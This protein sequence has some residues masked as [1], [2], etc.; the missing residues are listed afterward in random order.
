MQIWVDAD[1]C[2]KI[3]KE[4]LFRT[5]ERVK[6]NVT[7]V[8]NN[9]S[10]TPSS[11]YIQTIQVG[12]GY[13]VADKEIV[14]KLQSGDLVITAD[15][16][17]AAEVIKKGGFALSP[18][19]EFYTTENVQ[20]FLSIRNFM[21]ELRSSGVNTGGPPA[22]SMKDRHAFANQLHRFLEKHSKKQDYAEELHE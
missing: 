9:K 16:P 19:G 13:D 10:W 12:A 8:A 2:P 21:H 1:A 22:F 4:L 5:A 20:S 6:L 7:F 15:I 11:I 3:I 18:R 17:L 14:L